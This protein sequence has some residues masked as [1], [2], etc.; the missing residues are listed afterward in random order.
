[1]VTELSERVFTECTPTHTD[2]RNNLRDTGYNC[3]AS[4]QVL[5]KFDVG[6]NTSECST[7]RYR[8]IQCNSVEIVGL[9]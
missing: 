3:Y 9:H 5:N 1:M 4:D 2:C 6:L 8:R 7:W